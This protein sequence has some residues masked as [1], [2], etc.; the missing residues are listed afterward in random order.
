M[1]VECNQENISCCV[2]AGGVSF[3]SAESQKFWK[4]WGKIHEPPRAKSFLKTAHG[5]VARIPEYISNPFD[6][7]DR[8][9]M[10]MGT[11]ERATTKKAK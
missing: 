5:G 7:G 9:N 11:L 2:E 1:A 6:R 3:G 10:K 4:I 8:K